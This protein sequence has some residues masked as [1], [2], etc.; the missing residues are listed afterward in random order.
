MLHVG[1]YDA[2]RWEGGRH[3]PLASASTFSPH[4]TTPARAF[5]TKAP[6]LTSTRI[7]PAYPTPV[8]APS[9]HPAGWPHPGPCHHPASSTGGES[10][11]CRAPASSPSPQQVRNPLLDHPA[12][13]DPTRTPFNPSPAATN[14]LISAI[15]ADFN[16]SLAGLAEEYNTSLES[17][18]LWMARP[19]IAERLDALASACAARV[20]IVAS[21]FLPLAVESLRSVL[22]DFRDLHSNSLCDTSNPRAL[23]TRA[24]AAE[25]ARRAASTLLRLANFTPGARPPRPPRPQPPLPAPSPTHPIQPSTPPRDHSQHPAP[26]HSPSPHGPLPPPV[27]SAV[28]PVPGPAP[29]P[30][31]PTRHSGSTPT[32]TASAPRASESSAGHTLRPTPLLTRRPRDRPPG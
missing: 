25:T 12:A 1:I 15:A 11:G 31:S 18:T 10:A 6:A 29:V 4:P 32:I 14:A 22:A 20:R 7:S 17:L 8:T 2:C 30:L 28:A 21:N 19:D 27:A 3:A 9:S 16:S 13:T 5:Q 23:A 24:R 26:P